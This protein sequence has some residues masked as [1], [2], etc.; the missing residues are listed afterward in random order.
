AEA[1]LNHA[2]LVLLVYSVRTLPKDEA[3]ALPLLSEHQRLAV[4][5]AFCEARPGIEPAIC[6]HGLLAEQVD[7]A[8]AR[9]P[10]SDLA[11]IMGSDKVRQLLDP[12]W[13]EDREQ[14][15]RFLFSRARVLYAV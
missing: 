13:Y 14:A 6:S 10:S 11:R 4:L 8:A 12:K 1:A 3:V 7:A 2:D 5:E 15:L 9:F